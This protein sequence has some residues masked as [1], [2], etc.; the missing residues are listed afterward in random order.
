MYLIDIIYDVD[1]LSHTNGLK[2]GH[3]TP[4]MVKCVGDNKG[5]G[6]IVPME[7]MGQLGP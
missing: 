6:W 7:V 5:P 3:I 4:Y 1:D 2:L